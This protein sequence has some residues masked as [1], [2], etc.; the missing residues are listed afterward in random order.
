MGMDGQ[1]LTKRREALNLSRQ[2]LADYIGISMVTI[3]RIETA[4]QRPTPL[5]T[6]VIDET[7]TK[8]EAESVADVEQAG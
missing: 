1:T 2:Q 4:G 7:L 8:L 3:W 6:R 5:M